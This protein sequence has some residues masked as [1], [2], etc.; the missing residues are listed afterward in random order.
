[1][2]LDAIAG[3]FSFALGVSL[4]ILVAASAFTAIFLFA[5]RGAGI[6]TWTGRE[7]KRKKEKVLPEPKEKKPFYENLSDEDVSKKVIE[8][9]AELDLWV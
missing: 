5:V 3:G 9:A 7:K 4:F 2:A 6:A 8:A 1:M